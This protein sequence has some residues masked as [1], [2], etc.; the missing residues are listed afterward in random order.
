MLEMRIAINLFRILFSPSLLT[1]AYQILFLPLSHRRGNSP[2][3]SNI[4]P[5]RV[6]PEVLG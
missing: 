1:S 4:V 2:V 5:H 3:R 6:I